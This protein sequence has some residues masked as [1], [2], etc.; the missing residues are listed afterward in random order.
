MDD[1]KIYLQGKEITTPYY[2]NKAVNELIANKEVIS[3]NGET[4]DTLK[5]DATLKVLPR[6]NKLNFLIYIYGIKSDSTGTVTSFNNL[7]GLYEIYYL[8]DGIASFRSIDSYVDD[9]PD[10][11]TGTTSISKYR[12]T[13]DMTFDE[14]GVTYFGKGDQGNE[15]LSV[16][17]TNNDYSNPYLPQFDGSPATKKYVDNY[18]LW[19]GKKLIEIDARNYKASDIIAKVNE[20]KDKIGLENIIFIVKD[21]RSPSDDPVRGLYV[22]Y[23]SETDSWGKYIHKYVSLDQNYI[24]VTSNDY[25]YS[26]IRRFYSNITLTQDS[27]DLPEI[28]KFGILDGNLQSAGYSFIPIG[29]TLKQAYMPYYDYNPVTK[30]YVDATSEFI[31]TEVTYWV[32]DHEYIPG[33]LCIFEGEVYEC[34]NRVSNNTNKNN[35]SI[36][37]ENWRHLAKD[38]T[39]RFRVATHEHVTKTARN[40][41][42]DGNANE[43]NALTASEQ[44]NFLIAI[45]EPMADV[46]EDVTETLQV[47]LQ[48]GDLEEIEV[49]MT[50]DDADTQLDRIIEGG[51]L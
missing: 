11:N 9:I 6:L 27:E 15:Q 3:L 38:E 16:L 21:D 26:N 37:P 29:A 8:A 10:Y 28:T 12:I 18:A 17:E 5:A 42:F 30:K 50:E 7:H 36:A 32:Q 23:K 33:D 14:T 43:W 24:K 39:T 19:E 41:Y 20:I 35:P 51:E 25:G 22:Y 4:L 2:L 31:T 47:I 48:D 40:L 49:D 34:L 13:I 45:V 46:Q 1:S 44:D